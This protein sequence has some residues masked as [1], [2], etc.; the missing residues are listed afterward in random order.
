M[1]RPDY[2]V[3]LGV[4]RGETVDRIRTAYREL[5]KR[6]HPDRAGAPA[7]ARFREVTEAY[8]VLSDSERRRRY[9]DALARESRTARGVEPYR[10]AAEPLTDPGS[11]FAE[12]MSVR[13]LFGTIRPSL[14]DLVERLRRVTTGVGSPK[15]GRV[16]EVHVEVLLG[17]DEALLG[18]VI[19]VAVPLPG[20]CPA[21]GGGGQTWNGR[22]G[23]CGGR[24]V[25]ERDVPVR[26]RLPSIRRDTIFDAPLHDI[27]VPDVMLR[28]HVRI[29]P[30]SSLG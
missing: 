24:G 29:A 18:G 28:L 7:T 5:V 2:Y 9:N 10:P 3:V 17:A 20:W 14:D 16:D 13:S 8:E 21:C 19:D 25:V 12:P 1:R 6:Y 23:P 30:W 27:G 15:G 4:S 11:V 26:A 22:C